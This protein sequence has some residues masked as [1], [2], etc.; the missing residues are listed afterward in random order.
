MNKIGNQHYKSRFTYRKGQGDNNNDNKW[1]LRGGKGKPLPFIKVRCVS[2]SGFRTK[3]RITRGKI[4]DFKDRFKGVSL[5]NLAYYGGR[6]KQR[7]RRFGR[8]SREMVGRCL[9]NLEYMTKATSEEWKCVAKGVLWSLKL[10]RVLLPYYYHLRG[11][12][13][14]VFL[15]DLRALKPSPARTTSRRKKSGK[16]YDSHYLFRYDINKDVEYITEIVRVLL[17]SESSNDKETDGWNNMAVIS[18]KLYLRLLRLVYEG[19]LSEKEVN[20]LLYARSQWYNF[21]KMLKSV[22]KALTRGLDDY[23]RELTTRLREKYEQTLIVGFKDCMVNLERSLT[24]ATKRHLNEKNRE[25]LKRVFGLL[26]KG[27]TYDILANY[28]KQF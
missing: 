21:C 26:R 10:Y 16:I 5:L 4:S 9:K 20:E 23:R 27:I 22:E 6:A 1:R 18:A 28:L 15:S 3:N 14:T 11:M 25:I 2:A 7:G 12:D 24:Y 13:K 19:A 8:Y 17:I